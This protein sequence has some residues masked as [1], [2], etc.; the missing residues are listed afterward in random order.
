MQDDYLQA[1]ISK[2]VNGD[3]LSLAVDIAAICAPLTYRQTQSGLDKDLWRVAESEEFIRLVDVS[4]TMRF[5]RFSEKPEDRPG[6][7]YHPQPSI[8]VK[9]GVHKRRMRGTYGGNK[10]DYTGPVAAQTADLATVKLFLNSV[11]RVDTRSQTRHSRRDRFLSRD[12]S[13]AFRVHA[14]HARP[15]AGRHRGQV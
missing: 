10:S 3:D 15:A 6:S 2:A 13:D 8:K 14:H 4:K 1:A 7:Y 9:D 11:G 12:G 5:I